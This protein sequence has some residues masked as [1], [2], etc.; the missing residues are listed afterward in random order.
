M[1]GESGTNDMMKT[2]ISMGVVKASGLADK[3]PRLSVKE[4]T[5]KIN[6]RNAFADAPPKHHQLSDSPIAELDRIWK[7]TGTIKCR[8]MMSG[9][10]F[11]LK[12]SS[13]D[14][15]SGSNDDENY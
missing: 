14:I 5:Q 4:I 13:S 8:K 12:R 7:S 2:K 15:Y 9:S 11:D 3:N 10:S 6:S 1:I